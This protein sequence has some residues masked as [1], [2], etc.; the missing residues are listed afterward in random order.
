MPPSSPDRMSQ[1]PVSQPPAQEPMRE[2]RIGPRR[3]R[4]LG[5]AH[6]SRASTAQVRALLDGGGFDAVGVELC[7]ARYN[8][9]LDPE[10]LAHLDLLRVL[11]QGKAAMVAGNLALAAYQQRLAG[12]LGVEPGAEQRAAVDGALARGLPVLLLDR[13]LG[14]TL[15]RIVRGL[16]LWQ[17]LT[18]ISGLVAGFLTRERIEPGEVERLKQGDML[19][20]AFTEFARDRQALYRPLID[21]RDRYMAARLY[22]ELQQGDYRNL[23]V[24]VGAGHLRGIERHLREPPADA[25]ALIRELEQV[26]PASRWPRLLPWGIVLLVLAG[27]VWGFARSPAL[28]WS[29][30][31]DWV[32]VNGGLS[33]LGALLAA[34]HPL[35]VATAFLAAPVTSLNPTVGAGMVTAAVELWL[36]RPRVGDFTRLRHDTRS[37]RGWWRNRVSRTLLV[38]LLST[39][40]SALGTWLA[41]FLI[42]G[43]LSGPG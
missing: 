27:F 19:E 9:L 28:G 24:V 36:R 25:E 10:S 2:V 41:G 26:P 30:V 14:I 34:A 23:L 31:G 13:D 7:L 18:L 4:L 16:S 40:G 21:E 5:T 43:R 15:R 11:R 6:V 1:T 20:A 42:Y 17:R 12:Q 22:Q 35:T 33:A 8:A 29:L 37:L 32:L 38:F 39:L 3:L